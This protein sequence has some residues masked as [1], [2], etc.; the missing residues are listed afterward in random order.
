MAKPNSEEIQKFSI[1]VEEMAS[2]MGCNRLDA[3]L[4]HCETT[5]LEVEVASTLISNVLK[6][7]IREESEKD[8]L[9]KRTSKLPI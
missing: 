3:I 9:V 1:M 4:H 6:S 8:N 2:E 7:K 5:G